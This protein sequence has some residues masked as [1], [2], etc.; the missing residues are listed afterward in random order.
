MV[1]TKDFFAFSIANAAATAVLAIL[2]LI[3][4]LPNHE[5]NEM[6]VQK[7]TACPDLNS[8]KLVMRQEALSE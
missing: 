1:R 4:K 8:P 5:A 6:D 7:A 3:K 2:I